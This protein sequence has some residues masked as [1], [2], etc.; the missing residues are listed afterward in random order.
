MHALKGSFQKSKYGNSGDEMRTSVERKKHYAFTL[1]EL[2]VV[3]AIVSVLAAILFPVFARV[4]ENARRTSCLSNLKQIG[5]G[6][7]MYTQDYDEKFMLIAVNG[8]SNSNSSNSFGW[9][10]ALAP[11]LKSTQIFQCPSEPNG[12]PGSNSTFAVIPNSHQYTDY[13]YNVMVHGASLSSLDN[14]SLTVLSGD[15]GSERYD[16]ENTVSAY[17]YSRYFTGGGSASCET[18][19]LYNTARYEYGDNAGE[20]ARIVNDGYR[21]HLDGANFAFADGHV[22]WF[23]SYTEGPNK[24]RSTAVYNSC[25][26]TKHGNPTFG[27]QYEDLI[28]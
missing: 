11:Y 27:F 22:K 14:A 13:W 1:I 16:D 25:T 10:D 12:P 20:L 3:I 26:G 6:A 2:L 4:R 24:F 7:R 19:S 18:M 5:L 21:R 17:G 9:A 15:G 23:K 28:Q 8:L